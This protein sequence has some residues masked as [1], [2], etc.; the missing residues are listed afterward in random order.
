MSAWRGA[1]LLS[2][3]AVRLAVLNQTSFGSARK[4]LRPSAGSSDHLPDVCRAR[5]CRPP[6]HTLRSPDLRGWRQ[7]GSGAALR[8]E[9]ARRHY[10]RVCDHGLA[11][12]GGFVLAARLNSAEAVAG[13]G[14][15][16]TVIASVVIGGTSLFGGLGTIFASRHR[17]H[18][19]WGPAQRS[20]L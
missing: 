15:E 10:Q 6:L 8:A 9:R 7:P 4:D 11:G 5:S 3:L 13:T 12:L 18:P 1:A 16:L 14:Y 2:P 17:H 19:D 20:R